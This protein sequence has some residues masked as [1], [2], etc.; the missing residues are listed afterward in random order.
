MGLI[1]TAQALGL[2]PGTHHI[3][4][5]IADAGDYVLDSAVFIQTGSFAGIRIFN[6]PIYVEDGCTLN[7]WD[8]NPDSDSWE[9]NFTDSHN[10]NADPL[11]TEGYHL[12]QI[13]ARDIADTNSPCLDAGSD[14]AEALGLHRYTTR[15]DSVPDAN[16]VDMGYHY[17]PSS[18][19]GDIDFDGNIDMADLMVLSS[20]WLQEDCNLLGDLSRVWTL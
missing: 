16:I 13:E 10:I 19:P 4:L 8:W 20:Y 18:M 6:P 12:S 9:P 5:A 3:K 17:G 7:G 1:F 2:S 15:T 14:S 11:F